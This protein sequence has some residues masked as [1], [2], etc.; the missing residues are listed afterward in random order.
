MRVK[1]IFTSAI[2]LMLSLLALV[3][4]SLTSSIKT[5]YLG[6]SAETTIEI[7]HNVTVEYD[8]TYYSD[9]TNTT[10][11]KISLS[12]ITADNIYDFCGQLLGAPTKLIING[13]EV[14]IN[15]Y[16]FSYAKGA[17]NTFTAEPPLFVGAYKLKVVNNGTLEQ[18]IIN[19][20]VKAAGTGA[21][22]YYYPTFDYSSAAK[23]DPTA[24]YLYNFNGIS[25]TPKITIY[26]Q[27]GVQISNLANIK[28]E[29]IFSTASTEDIKTSAPIRVNTASGSYSLKL[30]STSS[31]VICSARSEKFNVVQ[32]KINISDPTLKIML[33]C[34][35]NNSD[36]IYFSK[37]MEIGAVSQTLS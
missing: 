4:L 32:T 37:Y 3:G 34:Y 27:N 1:K 28:Q 31:T 17:S 30:T 23:F 6:S 35:M 9:N 18:K 5:D 20:T 15:D 7:A 21:M 8:I 25:I 10:T 22:E 24:G 36:I 12:S 33:S 11:T 19:F 14:T 16:S 26:N 29:Y 13:V 2:I